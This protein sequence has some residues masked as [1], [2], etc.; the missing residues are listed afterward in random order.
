[1]LRERK[2]ASFSLQIVNMPLQEFRDLY[3]EYINA[4]AAYL[5]E[6]SSNPDSAALSRIE[7]LVIT[8][9]TCKTLRAPCLS[10]VFLSTS[11]AGRGTRISAGRLKPPAAV[12]G[13]AASFRKKI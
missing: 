5:L 6:L 11:R 3:R 4:L 9:W 2:R 10:Y 7:R 12:G 13:R 1:M 8:G